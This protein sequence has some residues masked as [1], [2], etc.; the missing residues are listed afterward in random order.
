[1]NIL[2]IMMIS[3]YEN[4]YGMTLIWSD[5]D[6]DDDDEHDHEDDEDHEDEDDHEASRCGV[7]ASSSKVAD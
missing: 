7:K 2:T 4:D 6:A 1:M 5:N 3:G